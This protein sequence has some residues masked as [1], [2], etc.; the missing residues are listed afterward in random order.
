MVLFH[1]LPFSAGWPL[2]PF[3]TALKPAATAY[4]LGLLRQIKLTCEVDS[5]DRGFLDDQSALQRVL[6]CQRLN[7][8]TAYSHFEELASNVNALTSNSDFQAHEVRVFLDLSLSL[9]VSGT[10]LPAYA[11]RTLHPLNICSCS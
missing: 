5:I 10:P 1:S 8:A 4:V 11:P 2:V 7:T 9:S 3:T 6:V